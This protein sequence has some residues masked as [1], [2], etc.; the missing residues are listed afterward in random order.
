[1]VRA[2]TPFLLSLFESELQVWGFALLIK[3]AG[4]VE[5]IYLANI[6]DVTPVWPFIHTLTLEIRSPSHMKDV[7]HLIDIKIHEWNIC[8]ECLLEFIWSYLHAHELI[9]KLRKVMSWGKEGLLMSAERKVIIFWW[10]ILKHFLSHF[11]WWIIHYTVEAN[12]C[13]VRN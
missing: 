10:K 5:Y 11:R 12:F 1:M 7:R 6:K 2:K 9:V 8:V 3:T 4:P 13:H